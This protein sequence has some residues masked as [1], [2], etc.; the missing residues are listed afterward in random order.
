MR[1][2]AARPSQVGPAQSVV[3]DRHAEFLFWRHFVDRVLSFLDDPA[4]AGGAGPSGVHR[5]RGIEHQ[6]DPGS[7]THAEELG[8]DLAFDRGDE[9]SFHL[10]I[11]IKNIVNRD[12]PTIELLT[13]TDNPIARIRRKCLLNSDSAIGKSGMIPASTFSNLNCGSVA[14]CFSSVTTHHMFGLAMLVAVAFS[15]GCATVSNQPLDEESV[16]RVQDQAL[17]PMGQ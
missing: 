13:F 2:R 8:R 14:G 16:Y 9:S 5:S 17:R 15:T 3:E 1:H 11:T 12:S 4:E 7:E 10:I 6:E